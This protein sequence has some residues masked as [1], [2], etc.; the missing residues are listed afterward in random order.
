MKYNLILV[1]GLPGTGKTTLS[2]KLYKLFAESGIQAELLLETN[3]KSPS[4]F[5]NIAGIP[6]IDYPNFSSEISPV[7][8]TNN[9]VFVNL[10]HC[11]DEIASQLQRYN[12]GNEFNKFISAKEYARCTLEWWKNWVNNCTNESVM[13][14]DSAF[15]QNPIN[16]M[17]FRKAANAE[18]EAY[19]QAISEILKPLNPI[20]VYLRRENAAT[21]IDF[22]KG[23]KGE[24]WAKGIDGLADIGCSDLFERRFILENALLSL[25]P[26]IVCNIN[27]YDWSD[28]ETKIQELLLNCKELIISKK[29]T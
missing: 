21:S 9:Y 1:E 17:I 16:E 28:A 19:I 3:E 10:G 12:V 4:D 23:V 8:V 22:A 18:V 26:N 5:Y 14:L 29:Y 11:T 2:E 25:L 6:K 20:C 24:H 27:G 7:T 15:M 13:I